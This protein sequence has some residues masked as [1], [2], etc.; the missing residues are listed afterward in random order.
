MTDDELV[1][2]ASVGL[3]DVEL[4]TPAIVQFISTLVQSMSLVESIA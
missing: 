2:E 1:P 4:R 3:E